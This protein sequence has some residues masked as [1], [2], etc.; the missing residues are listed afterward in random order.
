MALAISAPMVMTLITPTGNLVLAF[1]RVRILSSFLEK[2]R[3]PRRICAFPGKRAQI[4]HK[5]VIS[6]KTQAQILHGVTKLH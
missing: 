1:R 6:W 3:F 4:L 2:V 5:S